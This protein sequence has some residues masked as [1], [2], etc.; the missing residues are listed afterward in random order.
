MDCKSFDIYASSYI[1][2][3]LTPEEKQVFEQHLDECP[4]CKLEY[5]NFKLM[6]NSV[7]EI[8]EIPLPKDFSMELGKKLRQEAPLKKKF[9]SFRWKLVGC[10]A[11]G[12]LITVISGAMLSN[13]SFNMKSTEAPRAADAAMDSY[14]GIVN[15]EMATALDIG[16]DGMR[17]A[18]E[19]AMNF[20]MEDQEAEFSPAEPTLTEDTTMQTSRKIIQRG[21]ITVEVE[22][23][24]DMHQ[25]VLNLVEASNG[26]VQHSEIYYY[27]QNREKP[28][29][30]LKNAN[31]ELRVPSND[32]T[33]IFE[34]IKALGVVMEENTSGE[35][36]TESY[37]DIDNQVKNL[38]IQEERLRDILQKADRV[39]DLLQ[40]ENEL[41]RIRTQINYLTTTLRGYDGLVSMATIDLNI[42]QVKDEGLSLLSLNDD[43]WSRAKNNFIHSI[44]N[45][46]KM[47]ENG[48]VGLFG[49]L[50][51]LMILAVIG[52]PIGY[53]GYKK[54]KRKR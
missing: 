21:R 1:D 4:N 45:I 9:A 18:K 24:D 37:M 50:P 3:Y 41:N 23:F 33:R 49:M 13:L 31:M 28:E 14:G 6:I 12:L 11:A 52:G 26:F 40:I 27:F 5:E 51:P 8:E 54:W 15:N 2:D 42:R 20:A 10:I 30:S 17:Q 43:L 36:I 46:M 32:F 25:E 19:E 7:N 35:D 16:N 29:E 44:N 38:K 39:E 22:N 34:S 48:F 53:F 47:L